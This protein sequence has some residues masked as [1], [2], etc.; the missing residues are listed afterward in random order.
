MR[1]YL[2][3]QNEA[4]VHDK[5]EEYTENNEDLREDL[6]A[7]MKLGTHPEL[8]HNEPP[9]KPPDTVEGPAVDVDNTNNEEHEVE[10]GNKESSV[11]DEIPDLE[12]PA[13]SPSEQ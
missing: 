6:K 2:I 4:I 8:F 13:S 7:E 5:H 3:K 11:D 10:N 1:Q 9:D 12:N